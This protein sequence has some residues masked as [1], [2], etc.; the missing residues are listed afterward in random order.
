[1]W[2]QNVNQEKRKIF[3]AESLVCASNLYY[4]ITV[5]QERYI[6]KTY[7]YSVYVNFVI[8]LKL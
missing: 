7:L 2:N 6:A 4:S 5:D 3:V 1:M 8:L